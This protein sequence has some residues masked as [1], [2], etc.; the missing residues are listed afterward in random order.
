MGLEAPVP[1]KTEETPVRVALRVRPLLPKELLHG[2]QSCL[3]VEPE[4]KRVILGRNR[5]FDFDVVFAEASGQEMVYLTCVQPLLGAFFEGFNVTV[6]AYGQTGSGKTYT[7]GEASIAS[8]HEDEQ[9]IIPRAMAEAF[10]L[11]DEND[12]L[13]YTV[14]VSYLEVY[15]EEFRDLLEVG[16]ASRDI[17]LREDDKGNVV[18]CGVKEVEVEGLDEVL[19]L[20]E[21]GNAARHTGATHINRLSSRSHTVFTVTMEQRRGTGRLPRLPSMGP[22][23]GQLLSSKFHFVDLAG[24]E[25]VLK[26][27][28][29]GERLKES[30]QIN[31]SLLALGNVISALG[32]P[33]RKGS[34]I[35]YRDSKI[36]RI[37]KDSLGGNAKT[38]MIACISPSSSDFDET[39]NTLN[40]ANRAQNIRNCARINCRREPEH[41]EE[42]HL[43]IRSLQK[44]LEQRHRSE[45]R[46]IHRPEPVPRQPRAPESSSR[47][48]AECARYRA[49]TD[50]AYHLFLELQGEEA[51]SEEMSQKIREWLCTVEGERSSLS[52]SS[53]PDSG[54]E[55]SSVNDPCPRVPGTKPS[56]AQEHEGGG[57]QQ[58]L[59]SL[60]SQVA[61][62]EEE[63]KDFL[64]ALEDAMEQYKLQS[65]RLREQQDEIVKLQLRLEMTRPGWGPSELLQSL[66]LG[67][68]YL[69]PHTAPL[70][71]ARSHALG[72]SPTPL[73]P[74]NENES[75]QKE[76]LINKK[77]NGDEELEIVK[78]GSHSSSPSEEEE[79]EGEPKRSLHLR[80]KAIGNWNKKEAIQCHGEPH[81]ENKGLELNLED[82]ETSAHITRATGRKKEPSGCGQSLSVRASEWRLAQAQQKIR[83]LAINIRMKEELIG[84]LV[85]T[86]KAAQAMNRQHCQRIGE[87]EREADQVRAELNE[88]QRQLRELEGKE[89]QDPGERSRL[90]EFRKRVA[91]AQNQV[92]V[93]KEKKQATERLVSLSAQSEKRLRELERNVQLMRQQQGQLQKRLREETEQKR[94]LETEMH[95][96]QHRVKELELKHERQ[97]KVLKIKT[98]EIAA[99][100]RKRRS[101]SNGSVISLEQQQKIEE[102]KKWLDLEM[103]K[104]LEQRRALEELEEELRKRETILAKK[105]ALML[106]KTG[107]E[108]KRLRSSQALNEDIVRVSSRLEH[109]EKEL[110]EKSGQLRQGSAHSQQQIR[111][112]IDNLRQEKDLLLKQRLEIDSKLRQGNLL[113][114]EEERT[115]FQLDEA[116]EALDAAIEYKNEAITCRQRVLRASATMLSQCEMNLMAKLSYLSSSETRALLCKYFDK[117]VTLREEQHQQHI[118]FSEL[119]MQLEEQQRLVCWLEVAVERQRLEMDRQLTLQQKEH[120]QNIQLLLQQSREHLGEGLVGSK[121]QYENR[122]QSL[123]KEL[124]RYMWTNQELKQ[125]LN[126]LNSTGQ[127]KGG[128]KRIVC[129]ENRPSF[130]TGIEEETGTASEQFWQASLNEGTPKAREEIRD[131]VHAPLPLTWKRSSLS[132]DEQG[133]LEELRQRDGSES[134]FG[135]ILPMGEPLL[136]RNLSHLPKSRREL[137]RSSQGM[138]DVRKNPI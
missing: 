85:R 6:F 17:Q 24:S 121:R 112:E 93:L 18:L 94:R 31:S 34:H 41:V 99:F 23:S 107:L 36:T 61:R 128:E 138:I 83:E 3:E 88:G 28:N 16:T 84:E 35:P 132:N 111:V 82:L 79:E 108:S 4:E 1:P 113:S 63:N 51:L 72:M 14:R 40:Y 5:S 91:V 54:I 95:K 86:G 126:N 110:S 78:L 71:A 69:R 124:G 98:E 58:R 117:V 60:Q 46:I 65:D 97:Q 64:A 115:L 22:I 11:I 21:V 109:L 127:S 81:S 49:C 13:D 57:D 48:V 32:D 105:E 33:H 74:G 96:R 122:I 8:L 66:S 20:L 103:E 123:E 59:L 89:P 45:T 131:L 15:K 90:Q 29:T 101:G 73:I 19:S 130:V 43:Q 135:R 50:S 118:A 12:L 76:E 27:G 119:E 133:C 125:R 70:E 67:D 53:G 114:P 7:I 44:A 129:I 9:G 39:L 42:L 37:L 56:K 68:H 134:L 100:Q 75:T 136:P 62:L 137:R 30:I 102:Q 26:T 52:S 104:I 10:K 25:R 80:R 2:H 120:E 55:S 92:Q 47:L 77:E 116:I 106:E 38:V 87:L